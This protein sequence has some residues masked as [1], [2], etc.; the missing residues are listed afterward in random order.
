MIST[1][2]PEIFTQVV[3]R[4][5]SAEQETGVAECRPDASRNALRA[6]P[7]GLRE[8]PAA[9]RPIAEAISF[10]DLEY[11]VRGRSNR[12]GGQAR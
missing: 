7:P 6:V 9:I 1:E 12:L 8:P 10:P 2:E 4:N 5:S 3:D 11:V